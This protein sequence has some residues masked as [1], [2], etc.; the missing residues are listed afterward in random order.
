MYTYVVYIRMKKHSTKARSTTHVVDSHKYN[1]AL[2]VAKPLQVKFPILLR[3]LALQCVFVVL[4]NLQ[5][6]CAEVLTL[7][8]K[9]LLSGLTHN[10]L[11]AFQLVHNVMM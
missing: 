1:K 5:D 8:Q 10:P 2:H 7:R 3:C 11:Q 6:V 9:L 4:P